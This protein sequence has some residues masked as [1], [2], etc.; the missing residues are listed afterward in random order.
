MK[1]GYYYFAECGRIGKIL[2]TIGIIAAVIAIF[3]LIKGGLLPLI[4]ND[5][6]FSADNAW[7]LFF[8]AISIFAFAADLCIHKIC[9]DI[10]ALLKEVEENKKSSKSEL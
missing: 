3:F 10:A 2:L 6:Y 8:F 1:K 5:V 9:R 4:S 7:C